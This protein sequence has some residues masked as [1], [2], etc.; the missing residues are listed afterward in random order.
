[1]RGKD[2]RE[3]FE[4]ILPEK[5]LMEAVKAAGLQKRERKL[6]AL[7][8]LRAMIIA[9]A[10]GHGG[11][12]ADIMRV[13]IHG[14]NEKAISVV[15]GGFHAWFGKPLERVMEKISGLALEYARSRK[16]DLP[17]FFGQVR[18]GLDHCRFHN[19]EA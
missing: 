19:S 18:Q 10:S 4:T 15:R 8:L 9:A 11:R 16:R 5:T 14:F 2:V 12:Q 6:D 17:G 13:Y 3:I 7:R 1:M